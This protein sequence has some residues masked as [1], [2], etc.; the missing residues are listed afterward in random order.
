MT[1]VP[2]LDGKLDSCKR[3]V[4]SAAFLCWAELDQ[5][6][7][8]RVVAWVPLAFVDHHWIW[9]ERVI[10]FSPDGESIS[11]AL[12]QIRLRPEDES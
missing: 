7:T 2:S 10:E 11:P 12:D 6:I 5:L 3:A 4:A 9:S 1:E 8:E